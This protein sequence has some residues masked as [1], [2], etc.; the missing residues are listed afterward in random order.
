VTP[1]SETGESLEPGAANHTDK[2]LSHYLIRQLAGWYLERFE[3]ER[4]ATGAVEQETLD[5]EL[6]AVLAE[7]GVPA[8]FVEIQFERV[9]EVVHAPL[10]QGLGG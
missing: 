7:H 1:F 3:K 9:M 6:C 2:G 5:A 4:Q 10:G 8:E